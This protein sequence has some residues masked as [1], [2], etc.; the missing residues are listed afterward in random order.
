MRLF[1]SIA[2]LGASV[3]AIACKDVTP[4]SNLPAFR[5]FVLQSVNQNP[6]PTTIVAGLADTL[7]VLSAT[8]TLDSAGRAVTTHHFNE[9]YR[10]YPA[11]EYNQVWQLS[12]R[13]K[14]DSIEIGNFNPCPPNAD[15]MGSLHGNLIDSTLTIAQWYNPYPTNPIIYSYHLVQAY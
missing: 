8:V 9:F 10:G 14:G 3:G 7:E 1:R 15:C 12:Y 5:Y 6:V 2:F 11:Q 4:P 13:M